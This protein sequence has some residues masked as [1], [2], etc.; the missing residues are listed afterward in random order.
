MRFFAEKKIAVKST[1]RQLA[2]NAQNIIGQDSCNFKI[3]S[4]ILITYFKKLK[5]SNLFEVNLF[6]RNKK[7]DIYLHPPK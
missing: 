3:Y 7:K 6:C 2:G 1:P 4:Q 5:M